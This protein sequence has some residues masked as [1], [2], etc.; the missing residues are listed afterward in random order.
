M[1]MLGFGAEFLKS[2][3]DEGMLGIVLAELLGCW[4]CVLAPG[5]GDP[6]LGVVAG[7]GSRGVS[8]PA[9]TETVALGGASETVGAGAL[10]VVSWE[11]SAAGCPWCVRT[12]Q[13]PNP[14]AKARMPKDSVLRQLP[15]LGGDSWA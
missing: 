15:A 3:N 9:E 1:V 6:S 14:R 8:V 10:V 2:L 11:G 12:Q 4:F 5:V 13:V 7:L